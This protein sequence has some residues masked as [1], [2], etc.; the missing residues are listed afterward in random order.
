LL[1]RAQQLAADVYA[2]HLP[3]AELTIRQLDILSAVG[4]NPGLTQAKLVRITGIDRSTMADLIARLQERGLVA[5]GRMEKDARAKSV[6]LTAEGKAA[7]EACTPA[8]NA[9]DQAILKAL[10][11]G[12]RDLFVA[13]LQQIIEELDARERKRAKKRAQQSKELARKEKKRRKKLQAPPVAA[14]SPTAEAET[15]AM[16]EAG[17]KLAKQAAHAA[18][19]PSGGVGTQRP[20]S[21]KRTA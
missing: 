2:A 8:A 21:P 3:R 18:A 10:A 4:A 15:A 20:L 5:R 16:G 17:A 13:Q 11:K 14:H 12:K 1:H 6:S 7:L 19:D 9:A